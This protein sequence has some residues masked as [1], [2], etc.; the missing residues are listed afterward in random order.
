MAI[1]VEGEKD[2]VVVFP[3]SS[4]LSVIVLH[5][6]SSIELIKIILQDLL[7]KRQILEEVWR[8]TRECLWEPKR[9][10]Y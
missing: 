7:P 8:G 6:C 4:L 9:D 10:G 2:V 1:I 3:V 5:A